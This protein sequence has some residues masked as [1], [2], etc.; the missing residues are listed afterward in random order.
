MA[1]KGAR[2]VGGRARWGRRAAGV[3]LALVAVACAGIGAG[4]WYLRGSLP[5]LEGEVALPGLETPVRVERDDLGV[6]TVSG[7]GF[8][9]V[10]R[11]VGF[12]HA[13]DR[14]FQMDLLRRQAAGELAELF[15][16]AAAASDEAIRVHRFRARAERALAH[17]PADELAVL[18]A[19][20]AGVN[21]GL[22]SLGRLPFEYDLLRA[23]PRPWQPTDTLL[24]VFAMFIELHDERGRHESSLGVLH[25]LLPPPLASFLDAHGSEWDAPI[26]GDPFPLPPLPSPQVVDLRTH[27]ARARQRPEPSDGEL[28]SAGSNNWAVAG[29][30]TRHGGALLA[31]DMHLGLSVPNIWY[32]AQL[33]WRGQA[34]E[35]RVTGVTLP[36]TPLVVV[37]SNGRVAW[38]FT[39]AY[40]D[41]SD[42]VV[43]EEDPASGTYRTPTGRATPTRFREVVTVRGAVPRTVA[44]AETIW[45]PILDRDHRGR[46]RALRW[47]AHEPEAIN[48]GLLHMATAG[49]IEEAVELAR[50]TGIPPQN[51]VIADHRGR[52]AWTIMGRLP[53]RVGCD[54]RLPRSWADGTCR[55]EGLLEPAA[56][57]AV[58]DPPVGR[59]WTANSRVG[60]AAMVALLGDGGYTLGARARHIR[61]ELLAREGVSE[62]DMLA[63]QLDDRARLFLPWRERLLAV[64]TPAA[65]AQR[66]R[67][68]SLRALVEN[69]SG[70]AA[71]D[72]A[73][74]PYLRAF[75][76]QTLELTLDPLL[77][78]CRRADSRFRASS[79]TQA[80]GVVGRL[81]A[82][83]PAHLLNPRFASWEDLLLAAAEKAVTAV[84]G[85]DHRL[86][87]HRWGQRNTVVIAHPLSRAV[88]ALGPLLDMPRQPLPGDLYLP[89]VQS[90]DFGASQ[91]LVVS[92]GRE[93]EGL[94]HMP[95][96]QS[97]HPLSPFYRAGH[98]A[99]ATGEATPFLPGPPRHT[100]LLLPAP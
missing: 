13:Q 5:Q 64:L 40:V 45:G 50:R 26:V 9:D 25:D 32:R 72:D 49:S 8:L 63:L 38:G 80:E 56:V 17:L 74:Y 82:E 42:L 41:V 35:V 67:L 58:L 94:F 61:D 21:A 86:A 30:H 100:L 16:A 46:R 34:G 73:A 75:R 53:H 11:A 90:P 15:G 7:E 48:L 29:A 84:A 81:L 83:R 14:F 12:L 97:G 2:A 19:Y 92:P 99:W 44:V 68:A 59:L 95:G 27:A 69:W 10:A 20:S 3:A 24:V 18:A 88:P 89:R 33:R 6:P 23:G 1:G 70:R 36:G 93:G 52:I 39:N 66:P 47:T 22:E 31:N 98:T 71:T 96:G 78:P 43:L 77:A 91:R 55:W 57:P 62:R 60:D 28:P 4:V 65:L 76:Q 37:G 79:L 54:G 85:Q 87:R 51:V